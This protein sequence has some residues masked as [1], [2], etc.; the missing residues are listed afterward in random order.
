MRPIERGNLPVDNKNKPKVFSKYQDAKGD[1]IDRLGAYCSYCERRIDASLAVEHKQPKTKNPDLEL[2][3][4]NFLLGCANCNSTK[5]D[6][7]VRLDDYYWPDRD[8]TIRAFEY[9]QG[10]ILQVNSNLTNSE[11]ELAIKTLELTGLDKIPKNDSAN[12]DYRWLNRSKAWEKAEWSLR[13]LRRNDTP[14]MREQIVETAASRGF[15]SVWMTVFREDRD[16]LLRFI[17]AF[18][19]TCRSCFDGQGQSIARPGGFL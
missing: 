7:D 18:P 17:D 5:K 14:E 8:N 13:N 10:G 12:K 15:F 6:K 1:L 16:M 11:K 3:W 9:L 2:S 4:D 19:G